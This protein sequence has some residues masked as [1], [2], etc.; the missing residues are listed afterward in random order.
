MQQL[1]EECQATFDPNA[2]AALLHS[3]PYHLDA[4]L[5]M[6]DVYRSMGEH[7]AADE[8]GERCLY[9]LEM[10]WPATFTSA[11]TTGAGAHVA[12]EEASAPLFLAAAA[13]LGYVSRCQRSM[14]GGSS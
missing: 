14:A 6:A 5:T 13:M 9:A 1:Y 10:A 2:V 11:L 4:L 3:H 8:M 7:S 12:Y